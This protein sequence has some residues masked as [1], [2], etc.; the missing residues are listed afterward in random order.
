MV[1]VAIAVLAFALSASG[2]VR[3]PPFQLLFAR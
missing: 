1:A 2:T 3:K